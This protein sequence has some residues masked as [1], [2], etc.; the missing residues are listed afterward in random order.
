MI[1]TTLDKGWARPPASL[2]FDLPSITASGLRVR[3]FNISD[4][5]KYST[6]KWVRTS[7]V[8]GAYQA[9]LP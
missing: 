3:Y 2:T 8:A 4:K 1:S 6:A 7:C 9:R 5:A